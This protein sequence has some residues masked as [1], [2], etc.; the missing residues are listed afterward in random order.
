MASL[1]PL[2]EIAKWPKPNYVNPVTRGNG[3]VVLNVVLASISLAML[4]LRIY[5]RVYLKRWFG[6]DDIYM[7]IA[8]VF[9]IGLSTAII[10]AFQQ[11]YWNR[12]IWDVPLS[13]IKPTIKVGMAARMIFPTVIFFTRQSLLAF[14]SRL[15]QAP[16]IRWA[17]WTLRGAFAINIANWV[18]ITV[19]TCLI[20]IPMRTFWSLIPP[21]GAHCINQ[22]VLNLVASIINVLIDALVAVLP[23][24]TVL[25]MRLPLQQRV[26]TCALFSLGFIVIVAA[27]VR[28]WLTWKSLLAVDTTWASYDLFMVAT[29]EAYLGLIC[30]SAPALRP[31]TARYIEP[32]I[33]SV[34]RDIY[35]FIRGGFNSYGAGMGILPMEEAHRQ[36]TYISVDLPHISVTPSKS[37][38]TYDRKD[39]RT[40][41]IRVAADFEG[42]MSPTSPSAYSWHSRTMSKDSGHDDHQDGGFIGYAERVSACPMP[43]PRA[44]FIERP[45]SSSRPASLDIVAANAGTPRPLLE[46]RNSIRSTTSTRSSHSKRDSAGSDSIAMSSPPMSPR[47]CTLEITCTQRIEQTSMDVERAAQEDEQQQQ[48]QQQQQSPPPRDEESGRRG[49]VIRKSNKRLRSSKESFDLATLPGVPAAEPALGSPTR[50]TANAMAEPMLP[51]SLFRREPRKKR[52][53]RAA[54]ESFSSFRRQSAE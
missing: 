22:N 34:S 15:F 41:F 23:I 40:G 51:D 19:A 42:K 54:W 17:K 25:S 43:P 35:R 18:F 38:H 29:V 24:P 52:L 37:D 8:F 3:I 20:C 28:T 53:H 45:S 46:S 49:I 26:T 6:S 5:S 16:D 48:Q 30:A 1:Y 33:S 50:V 36:G 4:A 14:Y 9:A 7:I 27:C 13:T 12:H 44:V 10:L 2:D 31:Y 32:K 47:T 39:S 21:K 11:F